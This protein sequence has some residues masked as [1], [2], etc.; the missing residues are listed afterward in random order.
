MS[1]LPRRPANMRLILTMWVL[2]ITAWFAGALVGLPMVARSLMDLAATALGVV[3]LFSR[4]PVNR[5]HGLVKLGLQ[6]A[7]LAVAL[8]TFHRNG[9]TIDQLFASVRGFGR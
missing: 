2:A 7:L 4:V 1:A 6:A 3:L 5:I 9:V 8:I